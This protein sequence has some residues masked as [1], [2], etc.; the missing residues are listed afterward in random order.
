MHKFFGDVSVVTRRLFVALCWPVFFLG[1]MNAL[2]QPRLDPQIMKVA[3]CLRS[4]ISGESV[5]L[6]RLSCFKS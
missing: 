5:R 3:C 2:S 1:E 4:L 6:I